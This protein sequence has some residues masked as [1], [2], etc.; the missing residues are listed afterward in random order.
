MVMW[1]EIWISLITCNSTPFYSIEMGF[2]PEVIEFYA[3][4]YYQGFAISFLNFLM[5]NL[6]MTY[7]VTVAV[8]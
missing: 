4:N 6:D 1:W 7:D 2:S 3:K 8:I 5:P